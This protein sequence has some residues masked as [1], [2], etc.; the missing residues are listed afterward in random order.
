MLA[1][2]IEEVSEEVLYDVTR[3]TFDI[4]AKFSGSDTRLSQWDTALERY[5]QSFI[6]GA[7]GGGIFQGMNDIKIRRR[8]DSGNVD[9]NQELI[10]MIRNGKKSEIKRALTDLYKNQLL[11]NP[12]LGTR[13]ENVDNGE[14]VYKEGTADDN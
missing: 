3:S 2:G 7:I 13:M 11:G 1:E 14:I 9:A 5:G 12:N 10:Y 8:Y 4:L 6:G